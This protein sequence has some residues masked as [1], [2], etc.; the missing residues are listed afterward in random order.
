MFEQWLQSARQ[1][2]LFDAVFVRVNPRYLEQVAPLMSL[3]V[4]VAITASMESHVEQ[5][6]EWLGTVLSNIDL[7]DA[8]MKDMT[9]KIMD[10]LS[11]RLQ[12]AYMSMAERAPQDPALRKISALHRQV[13]EVKRLA[14]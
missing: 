7:N 4:S 10:I 14:G 12:G 1:A 11:Q 13:G 3:S 9:P 6:L 2:E 8:D 5:R